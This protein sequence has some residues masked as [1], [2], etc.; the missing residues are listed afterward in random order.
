[1]ATATKK[2]TRNERRLAKKAAAKKN[3][4]P[5]Q[6][7]RKPRAQRLPGMEDSGI[8]ELENLANDMADMIAQKKELTANEKTL[9]E[10]LVEAMKRHGKTVYSHRGIHINLSAT[11]KAKVVIKEVDD[12]PADPEPAPAPKVNAEAMAVHADV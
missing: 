8:Q 6:V 2:L 10:S 11:E 1:M 4:K 7:K 5:V 3:K 9:N 12:T